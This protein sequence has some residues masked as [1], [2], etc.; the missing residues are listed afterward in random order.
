M[1][2]NDM[3]INIYTLITARRKDEKKKK[4]ILNV[5]YEYTVPKKA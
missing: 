4:S 3:R 1:D 2:I 5:N